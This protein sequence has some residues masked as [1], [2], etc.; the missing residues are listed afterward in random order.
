MYSFRFIATLC[1]LLGFYI[2]VIVIRPSSSMPIEG[3]K[4]VSKLC[5]FF[6]MFSIYLH[7]DVVL[8]LHDAKQFL[9]LS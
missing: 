4:N 7:A 6:H 8:K 5:V 1:L 9:L 3:G 2:V